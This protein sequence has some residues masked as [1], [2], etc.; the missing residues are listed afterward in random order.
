VKCGEQRLIFDEKKKKAIA[1]CKE[2][3]LQVIFFRIFFFLKNTL[4]THVCQSKL[5]CKA[6]TLQSLLFVRK[7]IFF[8]LAPKPPAKINKKKKK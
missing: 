2:R 1:N 8:F 3:P 7:S 5:L 6:K 4:S